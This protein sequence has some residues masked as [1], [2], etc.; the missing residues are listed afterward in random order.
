MHGAHS[1]IAQVIV[2]A[3][4]GVVHADLIV[5]GCRALSSL[6]RA[7]VGSVSAKV[8]ASSACPV[9]VVKKPRSEAGAFLT[10]LP[11]RVCI[12][13]DG[14]KHSEAAFQWAINHMLNP[15]VD[16]VFLLCCRLRTSRAF[17]WLTSSAR[18]K[19]CEQLVQSAGACEQLCIKRGFNVIRIDVASGP[20]RFSASV[21]DSRPERVPFASSSTISSSTAAAAPNLVQAL[22]DELIHAS[23]NENCDLLVVSRECKGCTMLQ[24]SPF[25]IVVFGG[26]GECTQKDE[27]SQEPSTWDHSQVSS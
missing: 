18:A 13:I 9:M 10:V 24:H 2:N 26:R 19:A 4:N 25:P 5:V 6:K 7:L 22:P 14:T 17:S 23:L 16:E 3:A 15:D 27:T 11:R 12:H 21:G 8:A 1:K 20:S